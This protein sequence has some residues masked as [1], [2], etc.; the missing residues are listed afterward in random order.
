MKFYRTVGKE[1][2]IINF[3]RE[4][5]KTLQQKEFPEEVYKLT[6][7]KYFIKHKRI[8]RKPKDPEI[9]KMATSYLINKNMIKTEVK[10]STFLN[11][12]FFKKNIFDTDIFYEELKLK[13]PNSNIIIDPS[14]MERAEYTTQ[15]EQEIEERVISEKQK[16][17]DEQSKQLEAKIE[18]KKKELAS[19]PTRL[20]EAEIVEPEIIKPGKEN[21]EWWQTLNLKEDPIP[22]QEGF[23]KID[24]DYYDDIVVHTDIF[25]KYVNYSDNLQ[26][27]I[28][29]NTLLYGEFGSGKTSFFD[30]LK[31]I[32]SKN[33]I[34]LVYVQIWPS[35]DAE[36]IIL[37]F[38]TD[39][40]AS[41]KNESKKFGTNLD[42]IKNENYDYT[43]KQLFEELH[44]QHNFRGF[45]IV[46]DD[47]HKYDEA[48]DAVIRF[49]SSL[50]IFIS[51]LT[52]DSKFNA[53]A[54]VAGKPSWRSK[55]RSESSLS[56]SLIREEEMPE[57]AV[58]DAYSML[59][60]RMVAFSINPE[61]NHI[62]G[63]AFVK[64]VY[65]E[66]K[67]NN[68]KITFRT[69]LQKALDEFKIG[70]FDKVVI[71]NPSAISIEI[72]DN[73][74]KSIKELSKLNSQFEVLLTLIQNSNEENQ[75]RCFEL[76]GTIYLE[77]KLY[78]SNHLW[79]RN[80][81]GLQKL[82]QAGL[83][84]NHEDEN[85]VYWSH[86]KEIRTFNEKIINRYGVSLE[87]YL[88]RV[89][90]VNTVNKRRITHRPELQKLKKIQKNCTENNHKQILQ[91]A[92]NSYDEF[93]KINE[94]QIIDLTPNDL[95]NNCITVMSSLTRA[96]M[97]LNGISKI[98]GNDLDVLSFW[99]TFW[100]KPSLVIE[101]IDNIKSNTNLNSTV[102][103]YIFGICRDAIQVTVS[104]MTDQMEKNKIFQLSYA[105]LTDEDCK[106]IDL[107]R[108][109]WLH[110]DY[111][112]VA[113]IIS[114]HLEKKIRQT[115]FNIFK[116]FYGNA[117]YRYRRYS[118]EIISMMKN[119]ANIDQKKG[120]SKISNELQFLNRG[121]YKI[122]MTK[123]T[124]ENPSKSGEMN[125]NDIFAKIFSSWK[126]EDLFKF[127]DKFANINIAVA[128]NKTESIGRQNQPE[129]WSYLM[130]AISVIQKL[131]NSY[132]II[133]KSGVKTID[134]KY[135]FGFKKKLDTMNIENVSPKRERM[136]QI[137]DR[138]K[139]MEQ[140]DVN[141]ENPD[142]LESLYNIGYRE[143]IL[144]L[145]LL[146]NANPQ[147]QIK[148]GKL[149][150]KSE[151]NPHYIF[152]FVENTNSLN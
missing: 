75:Q 108:T 90:F 35:L 29:K 56:G 145:N 128:H 148:I 60:K 17:F 100:K 68:N 93:L 79:E 19:I 96:F 133:L 76:L 102:A 87:E 113:E 13:N 9:A 15:L 26:D 55:I 40:I 51:K 64:E 136:R 28:F 130:D 39:L 120:M 82:R 69:F 83:I 73:I 74:K 66:L 53:A 131:N 114:V 12:P 105:N 54:Y 59:N 44:L 71:I 30:Y 127:L 46:V 27:Q 8:L 138:F 52:R 126:Q 84:I 47:L 62:I 32:L 137:I 77:K 67:K 147:D 42:Y 143:F 132:D 104:F 139:K 142:Y 116:L 124:H 34:L 5:L 122:L 16:F 50:Q 106:K 99:T 41:L 107:C 25:N 37:D 95:V 38:K 14:E 49:L 91:D 63:N 33:K 112:C 57:I 80:Q 45:V 11:L 92:I 85:G 31:Q 20:D 6:K 117:E 36:K 151:K 70:N 98:Q 1:S 111:Y 58:S 48:F 129:T 123:N 97:V 152:K 135:Y 4:N 18:Q 146:L 24:T 109:H 149:V 2:I 89:F 23:Q 72:I 7:H 103:S 78:E 3:I 88:V 121:E 125:W 140:I 21:R 65:D 22:I 81:W 144:L 10:L 101:F 43:I 61:K 119:R 115:V 118:N 86:T 134:S 94:K 150:I 141:L 110:G